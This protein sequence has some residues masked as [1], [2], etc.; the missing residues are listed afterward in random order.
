ME[1]K[2]IAFTG[3]RPKKLCGWKHAS[4]KN[5]IDTL[6]L[7]LN[8]YY[9][10]GVRK[11]IS[12]AAQGFDMCAFLAVQK[13][14]NRYGYD[15]VQNVVYVPF[16]GQ[17]SIW[18]EYGC[19]GQLEYR[20]MLEDADEVKILVSSMPD[21]KL[22]PKLLCDRNTAM[23]KDCNILLALYNKDDWMDTKGGTQDAMVK[24]YTMGKEIHQIH[25]EIQDDQVR[26][27]RIQKLV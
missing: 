15:D 7:K 13:M 23:V 20:Q 22:L 25:Y 18:S 26:F 3:P 9:K 14:K 6:V 16:K 2:A 10:M 8:D 24:A 4:Y 19:F 17:E 27:K 1:T 11:F 5:L 12:G 21:V